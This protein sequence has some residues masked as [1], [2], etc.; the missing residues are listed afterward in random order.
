MD[1]KAAY[2]S[3]VEGVQHFDFTGE[4]IPCNLIV[5]GDDAFPVA[6]TPSGD[7][8]I[9]VS[10]YGK[11]RMVVLPHEVYM[12]IPRFTRFIQNAVNW[13]KPSPDALV[14]LQSSLGYSAT[15]LSCT[16][17]KVK[18]ND[19]YIEGMGVYCM[20]AYDDTQ[21]AELL[22]FVK[23]GGGLLIAGHAWHWSYS[24]TT[25]NVI[26]SFNGN[27][28][29]SAAGIYF[30]TEYG[31]RIVCPV[32]SEIPTS[33]LAVSEEYKT[34]FLESV[35]LFLK[36]GVGS[37]DSLT[38]FLL[39]ADK[40]HMEQ[41]YKKIRSMIEE[42]TQSVSKAETVSKYQL[43]NVDEKYLVLT[44]EKSNL[45]REKTNKTTELNNLK[46]SLASHNENL[47]NS[48]H[49]LEEAN[50]HKQTAQRDLDNARAKYYQEE[51]KRNIGIGL[52][53]IPF[54]GPIIGGTMIGISQTAMNNAADVTRNAEAAVSQ[55]TAE[56][57]NYTIKVSRY[58]DLINGKQNEISNTR[59]HLQEIDCTLQ[60]LSQKRTATA[61]VQ[62]KLR[63]ATH[64]LSTLAGRVQ[65]AEVQ[66]RSVLLFDPLITIL[67]DISQHID[68]LSGNEKYQL[69][70]QQDIKPMIDRLK[71]N[72]P[73]LK[74]IC[75]TG[76]GQFY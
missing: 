9:A 28:I 17:S 57:N 15:E 55:W 20:S 36:Q 69:L 34:K 51:E 33:S 29:T 62:K 3:L 7:V 11:G 61:E 63:D 40:E 21:A 31:Q 65:V 54:V 2:A 64:F 60:Q 24:H 6:V 13:L 76:D 12:M 75:N 26:F 49:A 66:T 52:M 70:Y 43:A 58:R 25:E 47:T 39:T 48:R 46:T 32:Q 73:K 22:S 68:Q 8:M 16:G 53:F 19:T 44:T 41:D 14:G 74:A 37:I 1:R 42:A 38:M 18:V 59:S 30:T 72:N 56:V 10:R 35:F 67:E 50:R 45:E 5:T 71:E 4:S 27:K 23:E